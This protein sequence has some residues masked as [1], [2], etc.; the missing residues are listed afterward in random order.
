MARR[1]R[2]EKFKYGYAKYFLLTKNFQVKIFQV[3]IFFFGKTNPY[4]FSH[5]YIKY[6]PVIMSLK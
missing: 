1:L 3:K 6:F 5:K 4:T 2:F